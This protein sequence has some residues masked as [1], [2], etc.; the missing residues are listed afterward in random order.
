MN[1]YILSVI[2]LILDLHMVDLIVSSIS[3]LFKLNIPEG[4][5]LS[6]LFL[7]GICSLCPSVIIS[8]TLIE[9]FGLTKGLIHTLRSIFSRD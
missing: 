3:V 4:F 7:Q 1:F 8:L 9:K 5:I 2:I 6:Y